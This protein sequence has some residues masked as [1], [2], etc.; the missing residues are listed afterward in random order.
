M[1][2]L[3]LKN[4]VLNKI[5]KGWCLSKSLCMPSTI[6]DC[7]CS[8]YCPKPFFVKSEDRCLVINYLKKETKN[9]WWS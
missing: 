8:E 3:K 9:S 2:V 1:Y 6:S 4:V 5:Y 7:A